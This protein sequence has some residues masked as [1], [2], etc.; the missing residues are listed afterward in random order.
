MMEVAPAM[1]SDIKYIDHLQ[2]INA[3]A[4]S[5]YPT[6]VFEREVAKA[7]LLL[8]RVN[9]EPAGY[10]YIGAM[11]NTLRIHQACIEYDLRGQLY[12]A[13]LIRHLQ[14]LTTGSVV[15]EI[16][17]RCG[18]DIAANGFWRA[19]GFQCTGVGLG[20]AR[21]M[22]DINAWRLEVQPSLFDLPIVQPSGKAQDARAWAAGRRR[23]LSSNRFLRGQ[24]S[25]GYRAL[26]EGAY[27]GRKR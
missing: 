17:L 7:R 16:V 25:G 22:R 12:G 18:S 5:F 13:A 1:A 4:L 6:A 27:A 20:G 10:L 2:K 24:N 19:M 15:T 14:M 23:G 26:V 9:A 11:R 3:D 21:R 8:A